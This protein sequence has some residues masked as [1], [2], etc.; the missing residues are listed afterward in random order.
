[1]ELNI[2][3]PEGSMRPDTSDVHHFIKEAPSAIS[4]VKT[5]E[6]YC[7]RFHPFEGSNVLRGTF[8][9]ELR[10]TAGEME[11]LALNIAER[12]KEY[13]EPQIGEKPNLASLT[14][15]IGDA[16]GKEMKGKAD[17]QAILFGILKDM[18]LEIAGLG[19]R[20]KAIEDK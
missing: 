17:I 3:K 20:I 9:G 13:P 4:I 1:M 19:R 14:A 11:Q 16:I 6:G 7:F 10:M 8:F 2:Y 18:A 12:L 15:S 5:G